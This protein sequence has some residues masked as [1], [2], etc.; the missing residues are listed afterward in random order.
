M[1]VVVVVVD[2]IETPPLFRISILPRHC[3]CWW[4]VY[5][6]WNFNFFALLFFGL[7]CFELKKYCFVLFEVFLVEL[8]NFKRVLIKLD[9]N[10]IYKKKQR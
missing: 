5:L 2:I 6:V 9:Y 8:I 1:V 4:I 10:K 7:I 3:V